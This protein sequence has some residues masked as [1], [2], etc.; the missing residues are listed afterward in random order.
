MNNAQSED[1]SSFNPPAP[2]DCKTGESEAQ[3]T[4]LPLKTAI[5]KSLNLKRTILPLK[6]VTLEIL[7]LKRTLPMK[8]VHLK[9]GNESFMV[10]LIK[11]W[12]PYPKIR[13]QSIL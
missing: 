12:Q 6:T 2:E 10:R 11:G 3:R 9:P 1:E 7:N 4:V 8:R 5:V 13:Q